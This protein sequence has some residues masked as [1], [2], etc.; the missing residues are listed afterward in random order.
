MLKQ[1]P[2]GTCATSPTI[3]RCESKEEHRQHIRQL[4]AKIWE[5]EQQVVCLKN[6][7]TPNPDRGE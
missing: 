7:R 5:R 2:A 1:Q 3:S 6:L 4:K